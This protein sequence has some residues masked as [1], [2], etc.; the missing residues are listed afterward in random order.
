MAKAAGRDPSTLQLIVRANVELT[1]QTLGKDR[2]LFSGTLEQVKEDVAACREIGAH[3]IF[4][5]PSFSPG[6]QVLSRWLELM[7]QLRTL[8]N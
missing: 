6:A 4:C 2:A 3:E 7:Q 5:D 1:D 8:S